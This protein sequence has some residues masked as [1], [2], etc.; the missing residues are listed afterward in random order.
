MACN[1]MSHLCN[2]PASCVCFS[3]AFSGQNEKTVAT[4]SQLFFRAFRGF[5]IQQKRG[6]LLK[7]VARTA[8][9]KDLI[10]LSPD[11]LAALHEQRTII[12]SQPVINYDDPDLNSECGDLGI[13]LAVIAGRAS[14][15]KSG[16]DCSWGK[17]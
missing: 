13:L 11:T 3:L 7:N 15:R 5:L 10:C 9:N 12:K 16:R 4:F 2:D 14:H 17:Y 8:S 6:P 1:K